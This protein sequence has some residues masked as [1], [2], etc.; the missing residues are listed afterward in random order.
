MRNAARTLIG[1]A[2]AIFLLSGASSSLAQDAND[3]PIEPA[4]DRDC[5]DDYGRDLCDPEGWLGIVE[6]FGVEAAEDAQANG[7]R[8]VRVFTIDGY[9]RDMPMV[10]V[11]YTEASEHGIPLN[12]RL[13]VRG[14]GDGEGPASSLSREA[15]FGLTLKSR[16]IVELATAAPPRQS[17]GDDGLPGTAGDEMII[18]LH[19]WVTV[20]EVLTDDGVLRRVRNACG[21]DPLFDA[22]YELSGQALRGFPVCSHL[23]PANYRNESAQ[24]DRCLVL[25]GDNQIAAAEVLNLLDG[26]IFDEASSIAAYAAPGIQI[27]GTSREKSLSG[28]LGLDDARVVRIY[29]ASIRAVGTDVRAR[30]IVHRYGDED[31][32][33]FAADVQQVWRK[34]DGAWRLVEFTLGPWEPM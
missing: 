9:S 19:A 27:S 25:E 11:L 8:G 3:D 34:T 15:W 28:A 14:A 7:W 6:T 10:S 22:G 13:E 32:N 4:F 33:D 30:G 31:G 5:M 29:T 1:M 21:D 18:C 24:L 20:T 23:D 12:P 26:P 17:A 2:A 16:R